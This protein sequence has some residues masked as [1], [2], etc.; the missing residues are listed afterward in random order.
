M[1]KALRREHNPT[2]GGE[3]RV[4][5]KMGQQSETQESHG[6]PRGMCSYVCEEYKLYFQHN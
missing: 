3:Q 2:H 5:T 1:G 4:V 6:H